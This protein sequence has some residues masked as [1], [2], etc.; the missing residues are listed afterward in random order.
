MTLDGVELTVCDDAEG[1]ASAVADE[2]VAAARLG[3]AIALTGGR[4]V[5]PAYELAAEREPDWSTA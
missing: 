1:V 3:A 2:L 5:G 4:S